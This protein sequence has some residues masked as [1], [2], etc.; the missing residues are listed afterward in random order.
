MMVLLVLPLLLSLPPSRIRLLLS[1]V[2]VL[3]LLLVLCKHQQHQHQPIHRAHAPH[4]PLADA[5]SLP[6]TAPG[7]KGQ[8]AFRDLCVTEWACY[9]PR[10][11]TATTSSLEYID[12]RP[13]D[14]IGKRRYLFSMTYS[15]IDTTLCL[16]GSFSTFMINISHKVQK[17]KHLRKYT[18][19]Y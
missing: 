4:C 15:L 9:R 2:V 8:T 10:T 5:T 1:M 16:F 12:S 3:M 11:A 18:D 17:N 7:T 19:K 6:D 14:I 13:R